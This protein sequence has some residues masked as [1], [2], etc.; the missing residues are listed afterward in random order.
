MYYLEKEY[1][2]KPKKNKMLDK[3]EHEK[4]RLMEIQVSDMS[5]VTKH[6]IKFNINKNVCRQLILDELRS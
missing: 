3:V 1:E 2:G 4:E 5:F 6:A